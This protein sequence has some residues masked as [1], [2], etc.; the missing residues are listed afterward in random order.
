[1]YTL[2]THIEVA[3]LNRNIGCIEIRKGSIV[4]KENMVLNRNIGCIEIVVQDFR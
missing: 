4:V 3:A 1:M 2:A